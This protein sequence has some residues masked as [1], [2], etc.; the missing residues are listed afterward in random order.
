MPK[1]DRI[2]QSIEKTLAELPLH[3]SPLELY[4]PMRY[5]L[6][7]GGKRFRPM[8]TVLAGG[9]FGGKEEVLLYGAAVV[10]VFHNFT[11]MH[12][13]IMDAAPLRRGNPTVHEKWDTPTAILSGDGMLVK[14][15]D[16]ILQTIPQEHILEVLAHFND[17][18]LG[19]VEGQ[20][21][22]MLYEGKDDVTEA[23][24]LEMIRL[25]TAILVGFALWLG[26]RLGGGTEGDAQNLRLAGEKMGL[27]F[28][29]H[30]DYLDTFGDPA[31]TGKQ[32][33][34]DI[35]VS[36]KTW[37]LIYTLT[38]LEEADKAILLQW[39]ADRNP[40][41]GDE[42]VREVSALMKKVGADEACRQ[43]SEQYYLEGLKMMENIGN[44]EI[45][46][47]SILDL[48][49]KLMQRSS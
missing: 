29:L 43:L 15:Y 49:D 45:Y 26:A 22:D 17:C 44:E 42:K 30:D 1:Q 25:K 31:L 35:R 10:E 2:L 27:G 14:V 33:G 19:V 24:Y 23:E 21:F 36:K 7:M 46:R 28:Q 32:P 12:D 39:L 6:A 11:L 20:Q 38:H 18:A 47:Q 9:L 40:E 4:A 3:G 13:D 48:A 5:I 34:G 8:L 41:R 37:L 16:I